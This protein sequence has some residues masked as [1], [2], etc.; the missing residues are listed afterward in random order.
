MTHDEE[1]ILALLKQAHNIMSDLECDHP[2]DNR[3]WSEGMNELLEVID[4]RDQRR[5]FPLEWETTEEE[6]LKSDDCL[7]NINKQIHGP[8]RKE[9]IGAAFSLL[10]HTKKEYREAVAD[11][12]SCR[13]APDE[14]KI[15]SNNAF[16]KKILILRLQ[17]AGIQFDIDGKTRDIIIHLDK[18][19]TDLEVKMPEQL[20]KMVRHPLPQ[21][22]GTSKKERV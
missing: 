1:R 4:R 9:D 20:C 10:E 18:H 5:H 21:L 16:A 12:R 3:K 6:I 22:V 19:I 8:V 7:K 15:M 2:Y 14:I 17:E 11:L 13:Y